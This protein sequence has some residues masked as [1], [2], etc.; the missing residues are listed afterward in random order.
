[1]GEAARRASSYAVD[2]I[3]TGLLLRYLMVA[4]LKVVVDFA[5]FNAVIAAIGESSSGQLIVANSFGF[6]GAAWLAHRLNARF[7]FRVES[8]P[9]DFR[10]FLAVSFVGG[11]LYNGAFIGLVATLGASGPIELNLAKLA[12]LGGSVA[13]N[14]I[15][16][17]L[18]V[19]RAQAASQEAPGRHDLHQDDRQNAA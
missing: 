19:F 14:F 4:A 10:R 12:A 2:A 13:W 5:L 16:S 17:A 11:L 1:M 6:L 7:T 18:F 15:G 3:R 8:R 9:G